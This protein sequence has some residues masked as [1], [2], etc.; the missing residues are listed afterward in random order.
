M[1]LNNNNYVLSLRTLNQLWKID[2][3]NGKILWKL[4]LNGNIPIEESS[5]FY[6]LNMQFMK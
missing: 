4:G 3:K 2:S 6:V 1:E 5:I